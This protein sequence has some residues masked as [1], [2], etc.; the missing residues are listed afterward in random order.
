MSRTAEK[1]SEMRIPKFM[2]KKFFRAYAR[3]YKVKLNEIVDPLDSFETFAAFFTRRVKPRSIDVD[4]SHLISPADSK[5]LKI[6]E[7]QED[8]CSIIKG[9][10]YSLGELLTGSKERLAVEQIQK[11]KKNPLN[12]LYQVIFYLAPGDYHRF[13]CP[14]DF[15]VSTREKIEGILLSVNERTLIKRKKV[16]EKNARVVLNGTW[17]SET[18]AS[19][20]MS[21]V[22]VGA[23]NVGRIIVQEKEMFQRGEEVGYFNLGSTIVMIFEAPEVA[24]WVKKEGEAVR[25]G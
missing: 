13:H 9:A 25:Y 2:R 18:E 4:P 16:Y 15:L 11:M 10:S 12:K 3:H 14:T 17:Q 24:E 19:F 1:V 7:I 21:M 5:I 23:L 22:M 6:A 8:E 20:A